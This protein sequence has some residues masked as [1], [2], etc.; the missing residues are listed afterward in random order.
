M[1]V[2][3]SSALLPYIGGG[4][5]GSAVTYGLTWVREHRRTV[6]SYRAPQRQAI[7]DILAAAHELRRCNLDASLA[8]ADMIELIRQDQTPTDG[9]Q[10]WATSS[11]QG[12][13][14]LAAERAMLV[15]RLTIVDA[16]SWEALAVA[17][18]ALDEVTSAIGSKAKAPPMKTADEIERYIDNLDALVEK[19]GDAV[20]ALVIGATD[21]LSPAES[22]RNRRDRR[23]ARRRLGERFPRPIEEQSIEGSEKS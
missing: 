15:G 21:R 10:L 11:A 14:L 16:P 5:L 2:E 8:M 6:D 12:D 19:Y 23:A 22:I 20:N 3:W 9:T 17:S 18:A 7:G 4:V 1:G 13:A